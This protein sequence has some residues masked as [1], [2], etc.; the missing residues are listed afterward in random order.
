M[1]INELLKE[2]NFDLTPEQ[3]RIA[4]FGRI[5]MDQAA[6]IK[7]DSLSNMMA[8]VG[9]ELTNFGAIFGPKNIQ[10]LISKTGATKE[11]IRKL[12][13]YAEKMEKEN[14]AISKDHND[15]GLDDTNNTDDDFDEPDDDAEIARQA[16][17][18][19]RDSREK[20]A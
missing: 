7:D 12:L 6:T 8:K 20:R 15:G 10:D 13:A 18:M 17:Q 3:R 14:I 1:K 2:D 4:N 16:D 19:A 5:L 9:N 11:V